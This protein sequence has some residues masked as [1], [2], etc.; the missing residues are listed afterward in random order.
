MTYLNLMVV[1]LT[2]LL[3]S[4][5]LLAVL[6]V[7]CLILL[8][9]KIRENQK[10]SNFIKSI[11]LEYTEILEVTRSGVWEWK[12][13]TNKISFDYT[14]KQLLNI[15]HFKSEFTLE[16]W[17]TLIDPVFGERFSEAIKK[18]EQGLSSAIIYEFS[19][20]N[21]QYK[22]R[23]YR[24]YGKVI[25][26]NSSG[27]PTWM[28]GIIT[29]ITNQKNAVKEIDF[30]NH[31]LKNVVKN[32]NS[33]IA[34]FDKDMNYLFVSDLFKEQFGITE[35]IIGKNHYELFPDIPQK[36]KEAHIKSLKGEVLSGNRDKF[37]RINGEV[38]YTN[39]STRPWYNKSDQIGGIITYIQVITDQVNNEKQLEY[40]SKR[41]ALTGVY[42]RSYFIEEFARFDK[43][44]N[45]PISV[46]LLDLNGLKLINDAYGLDH[47]DEILKLVS[48][49]LT[50]FCND[51]GDLFRMGGDAFAFLAVNTSES[52]IKGYIRLIH[53]RI[54]HLQYLN[55]NLSVSIGY[56]IKKDDHQSSSDIFKEAESQMYRRKILDT[57]SLR[58]NAIKGIIQTLN[59]KYK[60]EKE[61]S[62]RVQKL[63]KLMGEA[64]DLDKEDM[65][66][67][68]IA[69]LLHDIGKISIPDSILDKPSEL[70]DEEYEIMKTH[71]EKGYHILRAADGYSDLAKYALTHHER[72]DGKG[73]PHGLSGEDIP[74]FS[75]IIT[76]CDSYE[77]M[78][79]NRPYRKA[80]SKDYAI[81]E[82]I[83]HSNTQFDGR[84]VQIFI[85]KVIPKDTI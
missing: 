19:L 10:L 1:D 76:I 58:N 85:E 7:V 11:R 23:N 28:V 69:A 36:F 17:I 42:N 84:L 74:F 80:T 9:N 50:E 56:A 79:A 4:I 49:A 72:Y 15:H 2:T 14:L 57:T 59:D 20:I 41:D 64:L 29:D 16:E 25:E 65:N 60:V 39:W 46:I 6:F 32:S 43:E 68:T 51:I 3:V 53:E 12:K 66:E 40:I 70:T 82:L 24:C 81:S 37:M 5:I 75:R 67:L 52:L 30:M 83:K 13:S 73:Y 78:T 8:L 33:G 22:E 38:H 31:L 54:S 26:K 27:F 77:A 71:T 18:I 44:K 48:S 55:I 35:N 45:Y 34:I 21:N 62:E 61:H 63:C 47:G